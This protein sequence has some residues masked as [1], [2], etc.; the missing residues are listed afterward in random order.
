MCYNNVFNI[1]NHDNDVF[2][3]IQNGDW[4]IAYCYFNVFDDENVYV[5]HCCF[6][7]VL[8]A[9]MIDATVTLLST[10]KTRQKLK[11]HLIYAFDYD[12]YMNA[13]N[14]Y[15]KEPALTKYLYEK[16]ETLRDNILA[17]GLIP[18]D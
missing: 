9:E 4:K 13:L 1:I 15:P 10:F 12:E 7:D 3:K 16:N 2:K 11:Y 17:N 5:R 18:I 6:L 8:N 14:I